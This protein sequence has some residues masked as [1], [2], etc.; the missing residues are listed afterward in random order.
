M[1]V[2]KRKCTLSFFQN[3][4]G[5]SIVEFF[6]GLGLVF[7]FWR[8]GVACLFWSVYFG[9]VFPL[10]FPAI[11]QLKAKVFWWWQPMQIAFLKKLLFR[12]NWPSPTPLPSPDWIDITHQHWLFTGKTVLP[13]QFKGCRQWKSSSRKEKKKNQQNIWVFALHCIQTQKAVDELGQL[14]FTL[15]DLHLSGIFGM[16]LR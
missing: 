9:F 6:V 12:K 16:W 15:C 14:Q 5:F 10:N 7:F 1:V 4:G 3:C 11:K 2:R 13:Q 8:G